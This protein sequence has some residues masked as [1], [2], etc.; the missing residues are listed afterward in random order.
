MDHQAVSTTYPSPRH[1][2]VLITEVTR[3]AGDIRCVAGIAIEDLRMIRPLQ[4]SGSNWSLGANRSVF[5]VGHLVDVTP[6]GKRGTTHPH[7]AEDT[8]LARFPSVLERFDESTVYS[9]SV[10]ACGTSLTDAFGGN[11]LESSYVTIGTKCSSLAAIVVPRSRL[12]FHIDSWLKL[13]LIATDSDGTTFD[14]PV[15]SDS[16]LNRFNRAKEPSA[17]FSVEDAN[18]WLL[19]RRA[20]EGIILRV[21]LARPWDGRKD[22]NPKRCYLQLNGIIRPG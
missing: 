13:R 21:G 6:T 10:G 8:P 14:L 19:E 1:L 18:E 7:A 5:E 4:A 2:P 15:T 11:L 3:M 12:R 17:P 9:I 20:S 16:L 22:W